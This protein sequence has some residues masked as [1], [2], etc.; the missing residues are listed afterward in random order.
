MK[1]LTKYAD[2]QNASMSL[3]QAPEKGCKRKLGDFYKRFG[4]KSN[5]GR[6]KDFTTRDTHIRQPN[7]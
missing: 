7:K 5:K 3:K 1:G 6:N 2:R 4:F